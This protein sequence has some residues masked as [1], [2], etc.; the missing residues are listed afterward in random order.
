MHY[1]ASNRHT[2]NARA[3]EVIVTGATGLV[4]SH[5]VKQLLEDP[6]VSMI[7]TVGRRKTGIVHQRLTEFIYTPD[8][9]LADCPEL[10]AGTLINCL[11]TT[12]RNA[13]SREAFYAVDHDLVL[14]Y[15]KAWPSLRQF[16]TISAFGANADSGVFYNRVK[17]E[18]E[19]DLKS[20]NFE[21]LHIIRP[22]LL[23]GS[24][25]E[26]RL[27]ERLAEWV[28]RLL[29]PIMIGKLKKYRAIPA[30]TVALSL[31]ALVHQNK[32]GVFIHENDALPELAQK[33]QQSTVPHGND[34]T[35]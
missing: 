7:Y 10:R 28:M 8:H 24:R 22:S 32:P 35:D 18:V 13:G 6:S 5:L 20:C 4:G 17:G 9:P 16:I 21:T 34:K 26:F 27:G 3:M 1:T 12:M 23:T 15:A 25:S 19:E 11:G 29:A 31:R 33:V 30:G 2:F 14:F